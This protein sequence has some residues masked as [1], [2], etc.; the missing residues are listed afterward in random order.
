MPHFWSVFLIILFTAVSCCWKNKSYLLDFRYC[1]CVLFQGVRVGVNLVLGVMC[2]CVMCCCVTYF[3][4]YCDTGECA[5]VVWNQAQR[6]KV[7]SLG[8]LCQWLPF[9]QN[10]SGVYESSDVCFFSTRALRRRVG[11]GCVHEAYA[12]WASQSRFLGGVVLLCR[13]RA[14]RFSLKGQM[15]LRLKCEIDKFSAKGN[16]QYS[17]KWSQL[18]L[19]TSL[20]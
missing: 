1:L 12:S 10:N 17:R 8:Y 11:V 4:K 18:K 15:S 2:C 13:G 14:I 16:V 5:R 3:G 6:R 7:G 20:I 19:G 9:S